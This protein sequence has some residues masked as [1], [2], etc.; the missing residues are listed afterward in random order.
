MRAADDPAVI[1]C[2]ESA[3]EAFGAALAAACG[4]T[5]PVIFL[6]GDLGA[7]KTT[8]AR[9]FLRGL[10]HT[11]PVRSPTY[12]LVEPYELCGRRVCHLDLYRI[13]DPAE[14]EFLGL[15]DLLEDGAILLVEWPERGQGWLPVPDLA[16]RI[17]HHP[18]G[19]RLSWTAAG[20]LGERLAAALADAGSDAPDFSRKSI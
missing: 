8:L 18:G 15:R 13:A 9:G 5:H 14:L 1:L 16:I 10:G 2:S 20:G 11:G 3:Q 12:T 7:G 4:D 17:E 6:L 19:R